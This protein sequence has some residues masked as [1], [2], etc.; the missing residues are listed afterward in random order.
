L[1]NVPI[2]ECI[3]QRRRRR[4]RRRREAVEVEENKRTK[5]C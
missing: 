1:V 2:I 3:V 5:S 4:R